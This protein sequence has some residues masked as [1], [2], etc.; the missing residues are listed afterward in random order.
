VSL[1]RPGATEDLLRTIAPQV[2]GVLVRRFGDFDAAEDALQ[3]ALLAAAT[4]W[5]ADSVPG[6][7]R[8]WLIQAAARR[9]I[10][11]VRAEQARRRRELEAALRE[12]VGAEA[13]EGDDTL[14]LLLMC[15][16]P[17]LT[18]ASAI[19]LTL[20][21]V[22]GL[23]T[24]EIARAFL[25]P[26]AT[27][28]QRISRAKATIKQAGAR[29]EMPQ[30]DELRPRLRS[31]LHVLYL[32]FNEG[33]TSS[34]G[35][36]LQRV[37]LSGEAI[38]LARAVHALLPDD[39]EVGGLLALMLLTDARR[40]ARIGAAG[41]LIPLA[42][43]DRSLWDRA[44]IDEGVAVLSDALS[45]GAVGEYQL[46]ASIAALHDQATSVEQTD[47]AQILTLY[48]LLEQVSGNPVVTLNRAVAAAMVHGPSAGLRMLDGWTRS[49]A[50]RTASTPCARICTRW[51]ATSPPPRSTTGAPRRGRRAFPSRSTCRQRPRLCSSPA[52]EANVSQLGSCQPGRLSSTKASANASLRHAS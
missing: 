24:A 50:A 14:A 49:S 21:A 36:E 7:P 26:E 8:G 46:T 19:A 32:M 3:E 18:P 48:G 45:R 17:S 15:C 4:H 42:E 25:V 52:P 43:Q 39:G 51:R 22:A 6:N 16:H 38:R 20:R 2:L 13:V 33:Y 28:A 34:G 35:R 29:F 27:M 12:P 41:E 23:S 10:D 1:A 44:L 11:Q 9:I 5:P 31:A 47:W 40:P 30:G 37:E